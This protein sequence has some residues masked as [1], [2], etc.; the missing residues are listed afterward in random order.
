MSGQGVP[1]ICG[2]EDQVH[3]RSEFP[4][5][6]EDF[7]F[8]MDLTCRP[9]IALR[10]LQYTHRRIDQSEKVF[11][12]AEP[13]RFLDQVQALRLPLEIVISRTTVRSRPRQF[14]GLIVTTKFN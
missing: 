4:G 11:Q 5:R 3:I 14:E 8:R 10:A 6:S 13:N 1:R 12:L 9:G 2:A 7:L